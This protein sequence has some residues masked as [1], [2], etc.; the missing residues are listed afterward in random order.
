MELRMTMTTLPKLYIVAIT[1]LLNC[2]VTIA[3]ENAPRELRRLNAVKHKA[4]S[5]EKV[6]EKARDHQ[7][8]EPE[9]QSF[10]QTLFN[11]NDFALFVEETHKVITAQIAACGILNETEKIS[12]ETTLKDYCRLVFI[13]DK[14]N[15]CRKEAARL[16]LIQKELH[17]KIKYPQE[18]TPH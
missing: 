3:M 7:A 8:Y 2:F 18:K 14:L 16:E 15:Y 6:I 5:W 10:F 12:V 17:G 4:L 9:I 13:T 11:K 1:L